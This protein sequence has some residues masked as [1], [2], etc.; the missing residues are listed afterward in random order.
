VLGGAILG[1]RDFI[2]GPVQLMIRN[3]GPSMS[4]FN[5]WVLL[6]GLETMSLRVRHQSATA[7]ELA[8]WLEE[9]PQVARVRY[10]YL[11]SHP[12]HRLALAQ[13]TGG[14]TVVTFDLAV[15]DTADLPGA[16]RRAFAFLDALRVI[17]I[18][19][20]LGDA[21]SIVTHPATTT[22]RKLGPQGR[23]A[24]GIGETTVRLSVGLEDV[25]DLR[26]DL[27]QALTAS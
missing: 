24:V 8:R 18:S 1:Q 9:Q 16:K 14:G 27:G 5:A 12:Q 21:K 7:L 25:E 13:Q 6:K 20:N 15:P 10:P 23:A 22:H 19:N 3:T 11:P 17:D 2:G 4:P 26:A